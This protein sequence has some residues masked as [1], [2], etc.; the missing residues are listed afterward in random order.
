MTD[1][2][3]TLS[4]IIQQLDPLSFIPFALR[5]LS[6]MNEQV[7]KVTEC[8]KRKPRQQTVTQDY[9]DDAMTSM[10]FNKNAAVVESLKETLTNTPVA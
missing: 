2:M 9:L 10:A 4:L 7:V 3:L 6:L 5:S 1:G 8:I